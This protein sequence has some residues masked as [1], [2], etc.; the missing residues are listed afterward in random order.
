MELRPLRN[1][2]TVEVLKPAQTTASGLFIP[3]NAQD[4]RDPVQGLVIGTGG[5]KLADDGT[6]M[7]VPVSEG[8]IILFL[9]HAAI[10]VET[11]DGPVAVVDADHILAVVEYEDGEHPLREED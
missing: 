5:G 4:D 6:P 7:G 8:E 10:E 1:R 9:P 3:P 2:V 11:G